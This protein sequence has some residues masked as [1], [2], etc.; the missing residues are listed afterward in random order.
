FALIAWPFPGP[1][2]PMR[3]APRFPRSALPAGTTC[4]VLGPPGGRLGVMEMG[5]LEPAEAR[6]ARMAADHSS[7]RPDARGGSWGRAGC[8]GRSGGCSAAGD[9]A[10]A[11]GPAPPL[12]P[13]EK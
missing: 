1:G 10:V 9:P 11:A 12:P 3:I 13:P 6:R 4:S 2:T 7:G 5:L 8:A